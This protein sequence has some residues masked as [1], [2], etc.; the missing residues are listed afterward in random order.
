MKT[1]TNRIRCQR[2]NRRKHTESECSK[3]ERCHAFLNSERCFSLLTEILHLSRSISHPRLGNANLVQLRDNNFCI[4]APFLQRM[5][6]HAS[7]TGI[8]HSAQKG[9]ALSRLLEIPIQSTTRQ[10]S[11]KPVNSLETKFLSALS[12]SKVKRKF[13]EI[14]FSWHRAMNCIDGS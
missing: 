1:S 7:R 12:S 14:S 8:Y 4:D 13:L 10:H 6:L 2:H 5:M 11:N 3:N 9:E